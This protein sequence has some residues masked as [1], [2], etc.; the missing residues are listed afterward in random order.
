MGASSRCPRRTGKDKR[1]QKKKKV[2][3]ATDQHTI[4]SFPAKST[5]L[6]NRLLLPPSLIPEPPPPPLLLSPSQARALR[7]P[8][9]LDHLSL[10]LKKEHGPAATPEPLEGRRVEVSQVSKPSESL[11]L[12]GD[13][14]AEDDGVGVR[15]AKAPPTMMWRR[16][17]LRPL[18]PLSPFRG[19][20]NW[21]TASTRCSWLLAHS[22]PPPTAHHSSSACTISGGPSIWSTLNGFSVFST[23]CSSTNLCRVFYSMGKP[24]LSRAMASNIHANFLGFHL[25]DEKCLFGYARDHQRCIIFMV[26]IDAIGE[27]RFSEGTCDIREIQRTLME[28]LNHLD[29]FDELG[30]VRNMISLMYYA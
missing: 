20:S 5:P 23:A 26:E 1:K 15:R 28:L 22:L 18:L 8:L 21:P 14:S 10:P 12:Y 9:L 16:T 13:G 24:L 11:S 7:R 19:C 3:N 6:S 4:V 2:N 25:I 30:K 17:R 29:G 27:R